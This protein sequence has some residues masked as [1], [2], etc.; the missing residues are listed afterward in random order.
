MAIE[1]T[2]LLLFLAILLVEP[3]FAGWGH[4]PP[5]QPLTGYGS[6]DA[7]ITSS[8]QEFTQGSAAD[9]DLTWVY[10]P[11]QFKSGEQA[12]VVIFL[13][14]FAVLSPNLYRSHIE[15]L[16]QQGNIVIFPLFQKSTF[17]GFLLESGI[18]TPM[19]QSIWA[20][21]A[22]ASV[23]RALQSLA[24]QVSWNEIY[25]YGHSLGGLI[26]LAWQEEGGVP[27]RHMV[28]SHPQ[29]NAS[30]GMPDF[31]KAFVKVIEIPWQDY[32][33]DI[34]APV[35]ILNGVEDTI[36]TTSQSEEI[37]RLL[38][39]SPQLRYYVAQSDGYGYPPVSPN[40]GAPLDVIV[41]LP[42]HLKIFTISGEL[43]VLDW[44]FYFTALDAVMDGWPGE[45]PFQL[46][47]WSDG[48]PL[49]PV[50]VVVL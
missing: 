10:V 40:H 28:L 44:R 32:A 9:G 6:T 7:Y 12:P 27:L 47:E 36:A 1:R 17:W 23:D 24:D 22:V 19:D 2:S 29:V 4:R 34:S 14:G 45:L 30:A 16:V 25:L 33:P 3:V 50:E 38:I 42:P 8:W 35:V 46:G 11:D 5:E 18:F 20:R 31:V 43:D 26:A 13:H 21:R 39:K 48:T 15:H 49:R 41:G 37:Y